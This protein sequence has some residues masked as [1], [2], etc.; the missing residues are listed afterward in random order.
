MPEPDPILADAPST[1][2]AA[3][4][5]WTALLARA[6]IEGAGGDVRRLIAAVLDVPAARLLSEP[7][8]VLTPAQLATLS[9]Y[10]ARRARREPVSRILGR[11]DFYGRTFAVSP[12]TLDPRPESETLIEAALGVARKEGW[13]KR[14]L[15]IL[16][17][18]TGSGCLLLTLLCEME[19]AHG[20]GTDIS[21]AALAV[22]CDNADRLG[23][24]QRASWL[25]ADGLE[26]VPGTFHMLIGN[27]PYVRTSE[28]AHLE[29]EVCKFDPATALDGG[30]D[31]LAVY[32]SLAPRLARVVPDGWVILEVGHDQADGVIS[33]VADSLGQ[34][35]ADMRVYHDV[36]GQRRCVAMRT[37]AGTHA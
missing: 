20:I 32:R 1:A 12:A 23:V 35:V 9:G 25:V 14:R 13:E 2:G 26:T 31:G 17:V 4:R 37:R 18:G 8:R 24:S 29:P 19:G 6:G 10:V 5:A 11:R 15:R 22:A 7:E 34:A 27:P 3:L 30:T 33:I 16:D 28:I 21:P 36:A